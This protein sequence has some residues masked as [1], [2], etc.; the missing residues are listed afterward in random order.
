MDLDHGSLT[1]PSIFVTILS[2]A[3]MFVNEKHYSVGEC[4]SLFPNDRVRFCERNQP[5]RSS[6]YVEFC[7]HLILPHSNRHDEDD[8]KGATATHRSCGDIEFAPNRPVFVL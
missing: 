6:Q 5:S 8:V 2:S 4:M 7:L 3:G 1:K